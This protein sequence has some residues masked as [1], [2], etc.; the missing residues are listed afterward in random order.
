M[1]AGA[2]VP[3]RRVSPRRVQ[4]PPSICGL[5]LGP[6]WGKRLKKNVLRATQ[7]SGRGGTMEVLLAGDR[8]RLAGY[9][10]TVLRGEL[11]V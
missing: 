3:G 7:A 5:C 6:F 11:R 1:R 2:R 4:A 8:A 9:A 10:L